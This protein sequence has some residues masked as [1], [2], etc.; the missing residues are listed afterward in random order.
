MIERL[1]GVLDLEYGSY[2]NSAFIKKSDS[3]LSQLH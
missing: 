2:F 3:T 1:H